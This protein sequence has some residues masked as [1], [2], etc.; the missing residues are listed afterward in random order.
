MKEV[1][2]YTTLFFCFLCVLAFLVTCSDEQIEYEYIFKNEAI[3]QG[4]IIVKPLVPFNFKDK[5]ENLSPDGGFYVASPFSASVLSYPESYNDNDF[6]KIIYSSY[7]T[8]EFEWV[9]SIYNDFRD[10]YY[11]EIN[12]SRVTFRNKE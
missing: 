9:P 12:G 11:A 3:A 4:G 10:N 5:N 1:M 2:R 6:T 8:M 7:D